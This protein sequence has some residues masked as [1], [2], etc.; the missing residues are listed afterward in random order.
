MLRLVTALSQSPLWKDK[1]GQDLVEYALLAGF[2]TVA[3]AASF[4]PMGN[5]LTTIFSKLTSLLVQT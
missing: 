4:P 3:V 5:G 2:I 1:R